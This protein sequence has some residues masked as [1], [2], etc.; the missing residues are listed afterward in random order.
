MAANGVFGN[1]AG[2][3]GTG[4]A[5]KTIRYNVITNNSAGVRGGGVNNTGSLD[6]TLQRDRRQLSRR[7][8]EQW[9]AFEFG[10]VTSDNDWWGCNQ[11]SVNDSL[12]IVRLVR[13]A[14]VSLSG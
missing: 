10:V 2:I 14:L 11:G 6:L 1:G 3:P 12:A 13:L 8:G 9:L 5:T 7:C 4:N